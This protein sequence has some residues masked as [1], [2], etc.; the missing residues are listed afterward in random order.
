MGF[1]LYLIPVA[2]YLFYKWATANYDF[3]SKQGIAFQEPWP[4]VGSNFGLIFKRKPFVES[5]METYN[6]YKHEK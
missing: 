3:F 4:L 5:L 2:L 1:F 6:K